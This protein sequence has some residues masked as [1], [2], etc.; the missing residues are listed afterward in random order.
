MTSAVRHAV[1]ESDSHA[2]SQRSAVAAASVAVA[3]DSA[4]EVGDARRGISSC[5]AAHDRRQLRTDEN[6]KTSTEIIAAKRIQRSPNIN[7]GNTYDI[8]DRHRR[9]AATKSMTRSIVAS[10]ETSTLSGDVSSCPIRPFS[11]WPRIIPGKVLALRQRR[12]VC[13]ASP[14][15]TATPHRS[16]VE[17]RSICTSCDLSR[18][19]GAHASPWSGTSFSTRRT[20]MPISAANIPRVCSPRTGSTSRT[21]AIPN[22]WVV[23]SSAHP[24]RGGIWKVRRGGTSPARCRS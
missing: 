10:S 7:D 24:T 19:A 17:H 3:T 20:Q 12:D 11:R 6:S 5:S 13:T 2:H 1:H 22:G 8:F 15:P 23:Y 16:A 18:S 21:T 4:P 14:V 9:R